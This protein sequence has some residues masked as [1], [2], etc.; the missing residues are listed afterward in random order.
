MGK[1]HGWRID[2]GDAQVK[3]TDV[4]LDGPKR[5]V[6]ETLVMPDGKQVEWAYVDTPA[7]VLIVPVLPDGKMLMV[8]QYRY[9]LRRYVLEFPA[10]TVADGETPEIA[11]LRELEEETGYALADGAELRPLGRFYSLPSETNKYTH[12][13]V[14]QP[15]TSSRRAKHDA[16]IEQYFNMSVVAMEPRAIQAAIGDSVAGTETITALMLARQLTADLAE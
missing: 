10:G 15:V 2:M 7:S 9:N 4:L 14:A 11:A 1:D 6:C 3:S 8:Y 13:F 5:F 16:E 12:A